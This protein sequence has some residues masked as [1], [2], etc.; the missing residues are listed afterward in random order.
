[1]TPRRR[2][3]GAPRRLPRAVAMAALAVGLGS[4]IAPALAQSVV[5]AGS[6]GNFDVLNNTGKPTHGLEVEV[7]GISKSHLTRI[8][9]YWPAY[10]HVSGGNVIR[11]DAGTASDFPGGVYIRWVA[12]WDPATGRFVTET[13]V[14]PSMTTVPGDSCWRMGM[15]STYETAGCEHFGIS[16]TLNPTRILY[17]WLAADPANPGSVVRVGTEL[18]VPAPIWTVRPPAQPALPP[19]VVAEIQAPPPLQVARYG[20]ARWVKVYKRELQGRVDLIDWMGDNRN[21]VPEDPAEVELDW[22][23]VQEDPPRGGRQ[24]RRGKLVNQGGVGKG[25]HAV[26]RRYEHYKYSGAYD[27]ITNEALCA[28]LTCTA[29]S[30]GEL[31]AAIGAQN[32]AANVEVN[33]LTVAVTGGG[34]VNSVDGTYACGNTCYGVYDPGSTITRTAKP[35]SGSSFV[36]WG[37][38]YAGNVPTCTVVLNAESTVNA[39]F[40]TVAAGGGGGGGGGCRGTA[41]TCTVTMSADTKVQAKIPSE[42]MGLTN[43]RRGYSPAPCCR[44]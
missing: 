9:R 24:R 23:L 27:P 5:M 1:M 44:A 19:V 20:E 42:V 14:P 25:K 17:R 38:A 26:V 10:S 32:A 6:Y 8:F 43:A 36:T 37:G 13:P 4:A 33:A 31:G 12:P 35:N 11:Y 18:S 34:Q 3:L 16:S 7:H 15:P 39:T 21:V 40:A 29:P 22:S 2:S 28:D 41:N 30:P